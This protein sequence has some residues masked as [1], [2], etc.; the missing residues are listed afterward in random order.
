MAIEILDWNH[1]N[2]FHSNTA[3]LD[4]ILIELIPS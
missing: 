2:T 1:Q 3:L 4:T